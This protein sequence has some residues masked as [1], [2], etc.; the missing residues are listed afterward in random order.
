MAETGNYAALQSLYR[1]V[2]PYALAG[3]SNY[4]TTAAVAVAAAANGPFF[5]GGGTVRGSPETMTVAS[6]SLASPH[7]ITTPAIQNSPSATSCSPE[8]TQ[9]SPAVEMYYRQVQAMTAFQK[10]H[11]EN[12]G[13]IFPSG[14]NQDTS[15]PQI[16]AEDEQRLD[17]SSTST[18]LHVKSPS[19]TPMKSLINIEDVSFNLNSSSESPCPKMTVEDEKR[20]EKHTNTDG[21]IVLSSLDPSKEKSLEGIKVN[22]SFPLKPTPIVASNKQ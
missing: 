11:H 17:T 12:K 16:T 3:L 6:R 21:S 19:G 15:L 13:S 7:T 5:G 14:P 10:Q 9:L 22:S 4:G 1:G 18:I 20:V 8:N 2:S